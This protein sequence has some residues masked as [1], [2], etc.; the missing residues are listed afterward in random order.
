V[1]HLPP[2]TSGW[3]PVPF[4]KEY[5]A[6]DGMKWTDEHN[7]TQAVTDALGDTVLG[8]ASWVQDQTGLLPKL[9]LPYSWGDHAPNNYVRVSLPFGV[10]SGSEFD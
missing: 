8:I 4:G 5:R 3:T 1:P 2:K 7:W 6:P 10:D 9:K